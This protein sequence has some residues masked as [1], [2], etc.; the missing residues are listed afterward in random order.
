MGKCKLYKCYLL[1][2]IY[3]GN[4]GYKLNYIKNKEKNMTDKNS[5]ISTMSK[6]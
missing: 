5:M 6:V 3:Q 4:S 2:K 1:D